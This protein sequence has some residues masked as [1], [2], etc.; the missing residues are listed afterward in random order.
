MLRNYLSRTPTTLERTASEKDRQPTKQTTCEPANQRTSEPA[1]E[2]TT[3]SEEKK[4]QKQKPKKISLGLDR[5]E[6]R[7]PSDGASLPTPIPFGICQTRSTPGQQQKEKEA[8]KKAPKHCKHGPNCG[9]RNCGFV[10]PEGAETP[11]VRKANLK[12]FQ[13]AQRGQEVAA[14]RPVA[15]PRKG[16]VCRYGAK[17]GEPTCPFTHPPGAETRKDRNRNRRK[18][19]K[20]KKLAA[21]AQ[22]GEPSATRS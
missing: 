6:M 11:K 18:F 1:T 3:A 20:A 9:R 21:K 14:M 8:A 2:K 17:C 12:A 5:M 7:Q 19:Q 13:T 16:E 15:S 10:H 4:L 22:T